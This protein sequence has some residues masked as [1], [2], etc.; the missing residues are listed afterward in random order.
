MDGGAV[1]TDGLDE[2]EEDNHEG[3]EV[4][5]FAENVAKAPV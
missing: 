4:L 2:R 5:R 3:E 1:H